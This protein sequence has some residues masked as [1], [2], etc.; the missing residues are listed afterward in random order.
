MTTKWNLDPSHSEVQFKVKHMVISTVT[1]NFDNFSAD[2]ESNSDDF[3]NAKFEF[4]AKI[5]S[6]NTKNADR[7]GHLKSA[8]F[9]AADQFPE[10]KFES[11]SGIK[12]GKI[13]GTLEI[14]GEKKPITLEADFGGVIKDP[15]GLTRAGFEFSGDINRK[16]FGL[17]WSQVTEAGGLVVS[18]KVKLLVNLEFTQA[19]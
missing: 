14:R 8:D 19:Q 12:N 5:D 9:F 13:E 18:D 2:V 11:T 7:D 10:L 1:G 6:I 16:D 17:G 3:S 15:Y 4:D